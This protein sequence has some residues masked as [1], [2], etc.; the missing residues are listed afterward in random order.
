MAGVSSHR[1]FLQFYSLMQ[2]FLVYFLRFWDEKS[3][4]AEGEYSDAAMKSDV[5]IWLKKEQLVSGETIS[6][7][8]RILLAQEVKVK[9][10]LQRAFMEVSHVSKRNSEQ[11]GW[12]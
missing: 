1:R 7:H 8:V 11:Y 4:A 12:T 9:G 10:Q 2:Q 3:P 5:S 6:G